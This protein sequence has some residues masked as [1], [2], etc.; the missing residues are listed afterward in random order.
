M[1]KKKLLLF[2]F[3]VVLL[4]PLFVTSVSAGFV[5]GGGGGNPVKKLG[6]FFW[7]SEGVG[8]QQ[9][10][11]E[12]E[13]ILQSKGYTTYE[14]YNMT[15]GTTIYSIDTV[16]TFIDSLEDSND[17]LFFYFAGHGW[18]Y[19]QADMSVIY[20]KPGTFLSS[21]D[22]LSK[23]NLLE[24]TDVAIFVQGCYAGD[25]VDKFENKNGYLVM[26][27]SDQWHESF[28]DPITHESFFS[29]VF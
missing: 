22:L 14:F 15:R 20:V 8:N 12:Y 27:A 9:S 16:F 7:A 26:T 28:S 17:I 6:F 19:S 10:I 21:A 2:G 25:F 23:S 24:A 18:Y 4:S 11:D 29:H 13:Y 3:L 5:G 1:Y